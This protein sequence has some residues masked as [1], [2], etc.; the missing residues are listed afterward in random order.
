MEL[1]PAKC[2]RAHLCVS[3]QS[4]DGQ[5]KVGGRSDSDFLAFK[6][7]TV[8]GGTMRDM[9]VCIHSPSCLHGQYVPAQ[10]H[11]V[12]MLDDEVTDVRGRRVNRLLL[13]VKRVHLK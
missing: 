6:V 12:C 10:H 5:W 2:V 4:T 9:H 1:D 3:L 13:I 11:L 7:C 8:R